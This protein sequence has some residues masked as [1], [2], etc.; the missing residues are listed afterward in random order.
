M[1]QTI[2]N[3][4]LV[5]FYTAAAVFVV[6]AVTNDHALIAISVINVFG[7][8][9]FLVCDSFRHKVANDIERKMDGR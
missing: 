5:I 1:E 9:V 3:I 4:S 8:F 7:S 6:G 2:Y